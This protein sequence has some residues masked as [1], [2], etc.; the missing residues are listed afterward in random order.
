MKPM[1]NKILF[2][3]LL[4]LSLLSCSTSPD[5]SPGMLANIPI[6]NKV[7][8]DNSGEV[9]NK[10]YNQYSNW[11]G[12]EYKICGLSKSGI[13]SSGFVYATFRSQ[14]G[15]ELPRNT[16]QQLS[17]G[18]QIDKN[19]LKP[20]D[21]VFFKT[22]EKDGHVGIY[23]ENN[24]FLHASIDKGVMISKLNDVYWQSKYSRLGNE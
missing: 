18:T 8:L 22:T 7:D 20:G 21:L 16:E 14:L 23:L 17:A 2:L 12:V 4:N 6:G 5:I 19:E 9:K 24:N 15:I 13:D 1:L 11:K 10:L 3:L